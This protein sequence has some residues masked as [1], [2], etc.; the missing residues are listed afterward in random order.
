MHRAYL[1][2]FWWLGCVGAQAAA[3]KPPLTLDVALE[4]AVQASPRLQA[5]A[6]A[7]AAIEAEA[8]RAGALPDPMLMVGIDNLPVTGGSAFD[9]SVDEMTMRRVGVRQSFPASAK[10]DAR[11]AVASRQVG[12]ARAQA[13]VERL[14]V[15]RET[16]DAWVDA[17]AWQRGVLA[18][19][20]LQEQAS[21]VARL[22]RE[23]VASGTGTVAE[24]LAAEAAAL[25]LDIR[26]D[27]ARAEREAALASLRR[28]VPGATEVSAQERPEFG[29]LA[30]GREQ[31]LA[32][33]DELA[34]VL[35]HTARAETAAAAVDAA[36][37]ETRLDW[38]VSAS[39]GQRGRDRSDMLSVEL[40]VPL[41]LFA[42]SRQDRGTLA[43]EF[44]YRQA[45]ALRDDQRR[46]MVASVESAHA[47]WT[48]LRR[49][50]ALHEDQLLPVA[51]DRSSA[52]LASYRAGG[53]LQAWLD[54]RQA[55]LDIH[56]SHAEHLGEL[57]HA[58]AA[59]N[60]LLPES[61]P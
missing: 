4:R 48:S 17:W 33:A 5:R 58:W 23:R 10:R 25:A 2:A 3:P 47:R 19:E 8:S 7:V 12:E 21:L 39:Y 13:T 28:W 1:F 34:P 38:S 14:A 18:L 53:G 55:E 60:F 44:E 16:A 41:P 54:A 30:V 20:S 6:S 42:G 61:A 40:A 46:I 32:R 31:L 29:A 9:P 37:A 36:R 43:R 22:A 11:R 59:L 57:G 49:Q 26:I 35:G 56:R 50:V 51:R 24:A 27:Q 52:A 45:V 15:Q